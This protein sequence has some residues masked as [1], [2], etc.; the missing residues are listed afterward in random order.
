MKSQNIQKS[1]ISWMSGIFE[2]W[3]TIELKPNLKQI[4]EFNVV[5]VF[6]IF[7]VIGWS[8]HNLSF[9]TNSH[10]KTQ[11]TQWFKLPQ[12]KLIKFMVWDDVRCYQIDLEILKSNFR[13]VMTLVKLRCKQTSVSLFSIVWGAEN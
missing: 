6:S 5:L 3:L 8:D 11:I 1:K 9:V 2:L 7:V 13:N 4:S 10:V 12:N